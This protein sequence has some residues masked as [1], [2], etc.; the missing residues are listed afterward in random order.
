MVFGNVA[1]EKPVETTDDYVWR[2][3]VM[4]RRGSVSAIKGPGQL[5]K[6]IL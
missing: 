5:A 3:V 4:D 2:P 6:E 1:T